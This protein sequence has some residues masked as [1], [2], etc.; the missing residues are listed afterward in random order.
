[1]ARRELAVLK[2]RRER[3]EDLE[4]DANALLERYAV[5]VPEALDELTSE[6]RHRVYKMMRLN[7]VMY[8]DGLVEVTGAFGG[9]LDTSG[10]VSVPSTPTPTSPA[11]EGSS[12]I[13][14]PP[15]APGSSGCRRNRGT[16]R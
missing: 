4:Q 12:W 15:S 5:M 3:I 13:A 1:M 9:L 11:K 16:Y 8:A 10:M 6:E 7:L 14:S 2:E